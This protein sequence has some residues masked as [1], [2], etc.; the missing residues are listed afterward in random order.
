MKLKPSV[1]SRDW[2]KPKTPSSLS[3]NQRISEPYH[4][5]APES[6]RKTYSTPILITSDIKG[7]TLRATI[8]KIKFKAVLGKVV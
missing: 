1:K 6:Y 4:L 3:G 5:P 7:T 8:A 2:I